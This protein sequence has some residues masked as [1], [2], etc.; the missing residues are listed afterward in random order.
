M[1]REYFISY[2]WVSRE[3]PSTSK[4]ISNVILTLEKNQLDGNDIKEIE[5]RVYQLEVTQL[6]LLI[7]SHFLYNK[8]N[9]WIQI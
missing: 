2:Y 7:F 8:E 5:E 9:I 6:K 1:K 3:C 4:G